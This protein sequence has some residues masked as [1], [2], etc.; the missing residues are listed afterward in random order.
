MSVG[1]VSGRLTPD[2][3][4]SERLGCHAFALAS[5][6]EATLSAQDLPHA[7]AFVTAKVNADDTLSLA[8]LQDLG[9]RVVDAALTFE[10]PARAAPAPSGIRAA[11]AGDRSAVMAIAGTAFRYSRFHLDPHVPNAVADA[12]KADWA[13][14]FFSGERGTGMLVASGDEGAAARGFLLYIRQPDGRLIVDL[15]AVAPSAARRGL[16]GALMQAALGLAAPNPLVVGTQ[17]ANRASCRLYERIGLRFSR[18]QFVLHYH[19][20]PV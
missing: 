11:V 17:A 3:F 7:P 10:G 9:F 12:V 16:G 15:I 5:G 2:A 4:L 19:G 18:A 14:N 13:G 1:A 6:A 20:R 8:R